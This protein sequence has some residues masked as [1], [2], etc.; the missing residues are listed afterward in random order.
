MH[1]PG[2]PGDLARARTALAQPLLRG[3]GPL[4][5]TR[6]GTKDAATYL[7]G[8]SENTL[9]YWRYA[10]TGPRSFRLGRHTFYD[11]ADLDAWVAEQKA[12]TA[13]GGVK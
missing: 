13:I 12:A 10:G 9:R 2:L 11:V 7:G 6:L 5:P 1:S 3:T 8:L 4:T